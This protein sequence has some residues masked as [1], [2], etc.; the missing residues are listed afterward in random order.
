[1]TTEADFKRL[2]RARMSATGENYT[3]AR[4][5]LIDAREAS[6]AFYDKTI[7][8]FF[9]GERLRSIPARRKPRAVI[10]LHLLTRFE[11]G[12]VYAE[13]EVNQ[14]LGAAHEDHAFLRRELVNYGYLTRGDGRYQVNDRLPE[15]SGVLADEVPLI[16]TALLRDHRHASPAAQ[17]PRDTSAGQH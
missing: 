16:E 4:Q 12:R 5:A 11:P 9:D 2:V 7:R 15:R 14:I 1:M 10:L 13:P 8:T 6:T 17:Q 3:T